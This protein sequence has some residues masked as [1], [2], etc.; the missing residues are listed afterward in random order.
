VQGGSEKKKTT[1]KA[2]SRRAVKPVSEAIV[3]DHRWT[4]STISAGHDERY[5]RRNKLKNERGQ[6]RRPLGNSRRLQ[7]SKGGRTSGAAPSPTSHQHRQRRDRLEK[8][9]QREFRFSPTFQA[10]KQ[11]YGR[12]KTRPIGKTPVKKGSGVA[13]KS[14]KGK[15]TR[16]APWGGGSK[17][18][19]H[20]RFR[21]RTGILKIRC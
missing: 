20:S 8:Q 2:K 14:E 15:I 18:H 1:V 21:A 16:L 11:A 4:E 3:R 6:G 10:K 17:N 7:E 12:R 13:G 9:V 19:H 5:S